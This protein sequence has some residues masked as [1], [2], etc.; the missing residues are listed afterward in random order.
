MPTVKKNG[1][2]IAPPPAER[3]SPSGLF[4]LPADLPDDHPLITQPEPEPEPELSLEEQTRTLLDHGAVRCGR[5]VLLSQ[6]DLWKVGKSKAVCADTRAFI[7]GWADSGVD[8]W[9]NEMAHTGGK[10]LAGWD[11]LTAAKRAEMLRGM[12]RSLSEGRCLAEGAAMRLDGTEIPPLAS[13]ADVAALCLTLIAASVAKGH[14]F[15]CG[16]CVVEDPG[17]KLLAVLSKAPGAYE[18]RESLRGDRDGAVDQRAVGSAHLVDIIR[19]TALVG[20]VDTTDAAKT[21]L[22]FMCEKRNCLGVHE[23]TQHYPIELAV[24]SVCGAPAAL[25]YGDRKLTA[26]A[27]RRV[28]TDVRSAYDAF[29]MRWEEHRGDEPLRDADR[30]GA[31]WASSAADEVLALRLA[32]DRRLAEAAQRRNVAAEEWRSVT[33]EERVLFEHEATAAAADA[34]AGRAPAHSADDVKALLRTRDI[35]EQASVAEWFR[36]KAGDPA[37]YAQLGY[38]F[39]TRPLLATR[40]GWVAPTLVFGKAPIYPGNAEGWKQATLLVWETDVEGGVAVDSAA[41][42]SLIQ[43]TNPDRLLRPPSRGTDVSPRASLADS[44][45][46]RGKG[47]LVAGRGRGAV[48]VAEEDGNQKQQVNTLALDQALGVPQHERYAAEQERLQD[49]D[50]WVPVGPCRSAEQRPS[51][52][53]VRELRRARA[54]FGLDPGPAEIAHAHELRA[55][56]GAELTRLEL[57]LGKIASWDSQSTVVT[58]DQDALVDRYRGVKEQLQ[59]SHD[60]LERG[61]RC[62]FFPAAHWQCDRAALELEEWCRGRSSEGERAAQ[63]LRRE[64]LASCAATET[65]I[66]VAVTVSRANRKLRAK[67]SSN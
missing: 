16:S 11:V 59:A 21:P 61:C 7:A 10:T 23:I 60:F 67:P 28:Q 33:P 41:A 54:H 52:E 3:H 31:V 56:L 19:W 42:A 2:I 58:T 38:D 8:S 4:R 49:Q 5:E 14:G 64:L 62:L 12:Q 48:A 51:A 32:G 53:W 13:E 34:A 35:D 66:G 36:G 65:N 46:R 30:H 18:R 24:C 63:S 43:E 20:A 26:E 37:P 45:E 44:Q 29:A 40:G 22:K 6:A 55:L 57:E 15:V 17:H 1:E 25:D 47:E 50:R 27:R 39:A 9:A